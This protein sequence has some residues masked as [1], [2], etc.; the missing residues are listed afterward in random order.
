M[1]PECP[2]SPRSL[3]PGVFAAVATLATGA[4]DSAAVHVFAQTNATGVCQP[5]LPAYEGSIRKRPLAMQNEGGALAYVTCSPTSMYDQPYATFGARARLINRSAVQVT[6][7]CTGV[8]GT[9]LSSTAP[10]YFTS[11][12]PISPNSSNVVAWG[13]SQTPGFDSKLPFS[14]SCGLPPG[15]GIGIVISD[16]YGTVI[17]G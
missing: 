14:F 2:V 17:G 15:V 13:G 12:T 6:V 10:K 3:L 4:A 16:Q 7:Q 5:A 1:R 9:D 8:L 11:S